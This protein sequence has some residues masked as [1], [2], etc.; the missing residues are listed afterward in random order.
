MA[1]AKTLVL[2]VSKP[3]LTAAQLLAASVLLNTPWY[4]AA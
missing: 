3:L 2:P 4:V 1:S